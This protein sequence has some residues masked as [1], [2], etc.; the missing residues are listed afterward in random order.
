MTAV[1]SMH[2]MTKKVHG[3]KD[4]EEKYKN[5]IRTYPFHI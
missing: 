2:A 4:D 1:S 5:P 3:Y